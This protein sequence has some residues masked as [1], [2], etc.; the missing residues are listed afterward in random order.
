MPLIL[1]VKILLK[2]YLRF[3]HAVNY[4]VGDVRRSNDEC[5]KCEF[6][7]RCAGGCRSAALQADDNYYGVDPDACYFFKNG[8][9]DRIRAVA[10]PAFDA[11]IRRNY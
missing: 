8:W 9:E 3:L 7:E 5:R 10:Q 2:C 1:L 4:N 11:Y 6:N